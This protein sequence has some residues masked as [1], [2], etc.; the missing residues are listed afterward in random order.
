MF[1]PA[2][3]DDISVDFLNYL[4]TELDGQLCTQTLLELYQIY[5]RYVIQYKI[6]DLVP[7]RPELEFPETMAMNRRFIL[8]IGPTNSGKT[9]HALER[10]KTAKRAL[11]S[12][13]CAFWRLRYMKKCTTTAFPAPC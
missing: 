3:R 10:L 11:T 1:L 2:Q 13:R 6:M 9:F 12:V 5:K 4:E 8:H 7:S